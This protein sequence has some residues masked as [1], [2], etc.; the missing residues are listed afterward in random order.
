MCK[1][2]QVLED[3]PVG[4]IDGVCVCDIP[5]FKYARLTSCDVERS[6][7]Q[8]KSFRD[9]QHS[10]VM[11]NLEMTFVV[12]CNSRPTTSIQVW[13]LVQLPRF[14]HESLSSVRPVYVI[15]VYK[16]T[17]SNGPKERSRRARDLTAASDNLSAIEFRPGPR[18]GPD[19]Q[20]IIAQCREDAKFMVRKLLE[21]FEAGGLKVNMSKTEYLVIGGDGQNIKLPQGII[22]IVKEFKY[23]GSV[24][25]ETGNCKADIDYRIMQ[26]R[27]AI[28]MLN[29]VLW[30]RTIIMQTKNI[31]LEVI[32]ESILTYG[33]EGWSLSEGQKSKIQAVEMDGIRRGARISRLEKRR[34]EDVRRIMNMEESAI[35]RIENRQ[36]QWY[37][38]IRR[39]DEGRWPNVLLQWSPAGDNAGEKSPE[40]NTECYPAFAHIGLRENPGKN[41]KQVTCPDRESNPGHL[42]SRPDA[43]TVTGVD[44]KR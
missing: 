20:V 27:G 36:L 2:A 41:L 28:K 24:L 22:K 5:L 13:M 8:Y 25:H 10:F 37:G 40:S 6:F 43:L 33:A 7:S 12:Y 29:G 14:L 35:A 9:N 31:I 4:E 15:D 1:V 17:P 32:V 3:V 11:E 23:L 44:K 26:G 38:H 34:N 39:M 30:S 42:V 21:A 18:V 19:D 16:L